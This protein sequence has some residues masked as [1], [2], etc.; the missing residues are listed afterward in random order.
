[1]KR[2]TDSGRL[3]KR[4]TRVERVLARIC[5]GAGAHVKCNARL[6]DMNVGVSATDDRN[7]EVLAQDLPCFGGATLTID[8]TLRSASGRNSEAQPNAGSGWS[9]LAAGLHES[10]RGPLFYDSPSCSR[11]G[12]TVDQDAEHGLRAVLLQHL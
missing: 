10:T 6:R 12:A 5:R 1:M 8:V 2:A 7:I 3:K 9:L 11:L 4:A